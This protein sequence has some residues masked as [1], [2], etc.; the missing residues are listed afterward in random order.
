MNNSQEYKEVL[1]TDEL[2]TVK[3]E[4]IGYIVIVDTTRN[5]W[6]RPE[7]EHVNKIHFREKVLE[8]R[9]KNGKYYWVSSID[10]ANKVFK[11]KP[12]DYCQ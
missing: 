12:C 3:R 10:V 1:N 4:G 7:C 9:N 8:N 6:H 11:A 5:V 2:K